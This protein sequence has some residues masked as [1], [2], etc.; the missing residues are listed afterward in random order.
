[1]NAQMVV[2]IINSSD[3][4]V[5]ML[6][7]VLEQAGFLT[8]PAHVTDIRNGREDFIELVRANDPRVIVYDVSPPYEE[9]WTFL[10]LVLDTEV[11][12]GRGVVLTTTNKAALDRLV[13]PTD[14]IEILGKPYDLDAVVNAVRAAVGDTS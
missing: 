1:M 11:M 4:T 8:V 14:A 7:T 6:R 5:A 3:D 13:G 9:N 2:G 12:R 10:K